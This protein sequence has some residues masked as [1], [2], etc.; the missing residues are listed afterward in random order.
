MPSGPSKPMAAPAV[1]R[2]KAGTASARL[3]TQG[4][5][6]AAVSRPMQAHPTASRARHFAGGHSRRAEGRG[7]LTGPIGSGPLCTAVARS[8]TQVELDEAVL[9]AA[10]AVGGLMEF[11]GFKRNMG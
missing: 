4:K 9:R 1:A 11:W 2:V 3:V 7:I 8:M 6:P 5:A 10:D